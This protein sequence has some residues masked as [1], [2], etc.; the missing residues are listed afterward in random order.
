MPPKQAS[1]PAG[2]IWT[3]PQLQQAHVNAVV[4]KIY[5]VCYPP[6]DIDDPPTKYTNHW[7]FFL[8]ISPSQSLH[9]NPGPAPMTNKLRLEVT[10]KQYTVT[11]HGLFY[12]TLNPIQG[13][14]VK[15]ILNLIR[16][17]GLDKYTFDADGNGCR[18]WT[19]QFATRLEQAGKAANST[20]AVR[21]AERLAKTWTAGAN[22]QAV[23]LKPP[24]GT[25]ASPGRFG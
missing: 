8:Q 15:D 16:T 10:L 14:T 1:T 19:L 6:H 13:L 9:V 24:R 22:G 7:A 20:E 11:D 18:Y 25:P 5:F 12:V 21:V 3:P 4:Q 23:E 2:I 17:N